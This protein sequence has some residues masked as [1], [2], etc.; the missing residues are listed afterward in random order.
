LINIVQGE[1][2]IIVRDGVFIVIIPDAF[3][4]A[5]PKCFYA[6][7]PPLKASLRGEI[8]VPAFTT[9]TSTCTP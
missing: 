8:N 9:L 7:I 3:D 6:F 2:P 5:F 1:L 4:A